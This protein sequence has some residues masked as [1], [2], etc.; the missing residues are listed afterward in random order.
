MSERCTGQLPRVQTFRP[1]P[2]SNLIG[3]TS[4]GAAVLVLEVLVLTSW[5]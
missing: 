5:P 1:Q 2:Q 3:A 4:L